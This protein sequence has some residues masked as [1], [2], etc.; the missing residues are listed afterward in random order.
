MS[1]REGVN[2]KTQLLIISKINLIISEILTFHRLRNF[3]LYI[4][5][6]F[7]FFL[8]FKIGDF[9][10]TPRKSTD[11]QTNVLKTSSTVYRGF[12]SPILI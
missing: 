7:D 9:P 2:E 6:L 1:E 12:S 4:R 8:V 10:Y 3:E 5:I 11:I